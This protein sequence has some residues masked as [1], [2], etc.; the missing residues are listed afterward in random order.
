[1]AQTEWIA[2]RDDRIPNG[3]RLGRPQ[4][5]RPQ[6]ARIHAQQRNIGHRIGTDDLGDDL[7]SIR[8]AYSDAASADDDVPIRDD[9]TVLSNDEPRTESPGRAFLAR[10][11]TPRR[12]EQAP[13]NRSHRIGIRVGHRSSLSAQCGAI[14]RADTRL[15]HEYGYYTWRDPSDE[16]GIP[17]WLGA[18]NN[19]RQQA[20]ECDDGQPDSEHWS[21]AGFIDRHKTAE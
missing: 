11:V 20:R 6:T 5:K 8:Q 15:Y 13:K 16:R 18:K 7:A 2:D 19:A 21:I 4:V 9:K 10:R 14:R 3:Y 17:G 12:R 1:L